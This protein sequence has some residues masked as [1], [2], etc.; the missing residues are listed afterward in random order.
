MH[1]FGRYFGRYFGRWGSQG[2]RPEDRL[3]VQPNTIVLLPEQV[4]VSHTPGIGWRALIVDRYA[5]RAK[6]ATLTSDHD[7][8]TIFAEAG[9]RDRGFQ[10]VS[11]RS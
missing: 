7:G 11:P 4:T 8:H 5:C 10:F 9:G 2:L 6:T 3:F 1:L